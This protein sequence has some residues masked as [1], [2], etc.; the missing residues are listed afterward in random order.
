MSEDRQTQSASLAAMEENIIV[1]LH[2]S[3]TQGDAAAKSLFG[4]RGRK[5]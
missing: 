3:P 5:L 1:D 4:N 2:G